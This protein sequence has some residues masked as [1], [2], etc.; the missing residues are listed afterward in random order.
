LHFHGAMADLLLDA[1]FRQIVAA[2]LAG[3]ALSAAA[4]AAVSFSVLER[5]GPRLVAFAVG[6]LLATAFL[7]LLPEAAKTLD[8]EH[9]LGTCL[10]GILAFF[11]L[12]KIALWRH[13]HAGPPAAPR[14]GHKPAGMM[15]LIGDGVHN[16]VD[17]VV[18]AAAFLADPVLGWTAAAGIVAHEIPQE[19]G[20]F[21][22]L[23]A[24]GYS[25]RSA[26]ACNLAVSLASVAGGVV[27]YVALS[28][29]EAVIPYALAL[30]AASFIYI[31]AADLMPELNCRWDARTSGA[32]VAL[33]AAGVGALF[34]LHAH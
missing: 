2:T 4:A 16:F 34:L 21:A 32:E 1:P 12:E 13:E 9:V 15:I 28:Q 11:V 14:G 25:R 30:S 3:G 18:L 7:E 6:M 19:V 5:W 8:L 17:G 33:M 24:S 27:G 26:L 10:A 20:D 23:R 22:I 29:V 31:A